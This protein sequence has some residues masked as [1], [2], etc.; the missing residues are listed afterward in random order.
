MKTGNS[1]PEGQSDRSVNMPNHHH[2]LSTLATGWTVRGSNPGGDGIFRTRPDR[3][4]GLTSLL[5]N[6]YRVI[7]GGQAPGALTTHPI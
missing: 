2:I 3:P 7:P 4:L 5:Y 6:G 1:F